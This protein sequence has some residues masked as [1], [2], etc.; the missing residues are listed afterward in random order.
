M[1]TRKRTDEIKEKKPMFIHNN[2]FKKKYLL[3][4]GKPIGHV[5][6]NLAPSG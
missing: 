3:W 1:K 6:V 5:R 4:G 2:L